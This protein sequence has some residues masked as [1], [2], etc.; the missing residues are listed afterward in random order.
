M[1]DAQS[2]GWGPPC[3]DSQ[4]VS[5]SAG[6]R[7]FNVHRKVATIFQAFITELVDRG[8]PINKGQLDDWSYNCRK[9]SGSNTWSN[10]AWGLAVDINSLTN[11]MKSPLTTDMP[12]W[13]RNEADLMARYG[14]RWGG[15]YSGTPDP[16]HFEFM[17]TPADADRI[18]ATLGDGG[19]WWMGAIPADNVKQIRDACEAAVREV[20]SVSTGN[21]DTIQYGQVNNDKGWSI[22]AQYCKD[23]KAWQAANAVPSAEAIAAAVVAELP[24]G[25][26]ALEQIVAAFEQVI[27]DI[28]V[29][30]EVNQGTAQMGMEVKENESR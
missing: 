9:I 10:H 12:S 20:M 11:P 5:I 18:S 19:D 15:E 23:I 17:L 7:N 2:R 16:M 6:G 27:N 14:L 29:S 3:P 13:V 21:M 4:I 1:A 25:S 22:L 8:Y 24:E 28:V 26:V 30:V